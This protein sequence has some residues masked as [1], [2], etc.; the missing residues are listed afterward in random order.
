MAEKTAPRD[1]ALLRGLPER[2]RIHDLRHSAATLMYAQG[3]PARSIMEVLGHST[4]AMTA[5]YQ[6][7]L[8]EVMD[9]AARAMDRALGTG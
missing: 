8:P 9:D 3:V 4:L 5:R 7:V 2:L 1:R 6:H